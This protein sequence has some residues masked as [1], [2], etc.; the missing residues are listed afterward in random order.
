MKK[1]FYSTILFM[2]ISLCSFAQQGETPKRGDFDKKIEKELK[3]SDEQSKKMEELRETYRAKIAELRKDKQLSRE[4]RQTKMKELM[5]QQQAEMKGF[6][7]EDQLKQLE[8]RKPQFKRGLS[9][10]LQ[11]PAKNKGQYYHL[12]AQKGDGRFQHLPIEKKEYYF[13]YLNLTD[14]Q[15]E[16]LKDIN[17]DY[18]GKF[19]AL[20]EEKHKSIESLLT[21]EQKV[22]F[23]EAIK[24]REAKVNRQDSLRHKMDR[25]HNSSH[26]KM[27][28]NLPEDVAEKLKALDENFE[29]E[30]ETIKL[31]R[32]AP[33]MQDRRIKE[34]AEK[35]RKERQELLK[36]YCK[37]REVN[38]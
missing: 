29:K 24:N 27:M 28:K 10:R 18:A 9:G 13:S 34:A 21:P 7:T 16:K 20:N 5:D 38:K 8:A 3:L 19:K 2:S 22:K 12:P 4:D 1:L 30:K 11:P 15:K 26:N 25:K 37:I 14:E 31:T 36:D 32:I 17:K 33:A 23:E 35:Y 6:L